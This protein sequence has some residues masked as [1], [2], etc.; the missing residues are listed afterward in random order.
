[1][2][3]EILVGILAA[4]VVFAGL[5]EVNLWPLLVMAGG[6]L[7]VRYLAVEGR[8]PGGRRFEVV[9]G[10]GDGRSA[11]T[12]DDIGGQEMAKRELMEALD[13]VRQPERARRLGIRPL[14]G[15]LLAGP[16]GTGKTMMARAAAGY[17]DA[18]FLVASGSQFVEMYAGVGAQRVRELF[19]RARL[20][21]RQRRS[22][23]AIIFIDELEVLG[24][25]RGRHTSHLEYDQT[26][27]QLLVEMDGM[28]SRADDVQVLVIGATNRMDLLDPALLRPGRF[29]R[30]VRVDLPD[31][32]ARLQILR[33]HTRHRPLADDVD[34]EAVARE[35][36]GF[37]G[38]HLEAVVNEAA[39]AA[40]R[41]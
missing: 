16:P 15:I 10:E 14:R 5:N 28:G 31:R 17:T 11:V 7:A 20:L 6:F 32:E 39:I 22:R 40:L 36:F 3:R 25:R 24:G 35:T 27:N 4:A 12:F 1:M 29:D 21:A 23:T 30:V 33:I 34:L 8:M 26:L 38:A 37:S 18:A 13:F 9:Q 41:A 19:R 2:I